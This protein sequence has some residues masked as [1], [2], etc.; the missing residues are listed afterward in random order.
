MQIVVV[1]LKRLS[2]MGRVNEAPVDAE[3]RIRVSN[4]SQAGGAP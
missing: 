2:R 1:L 3:M 4:A